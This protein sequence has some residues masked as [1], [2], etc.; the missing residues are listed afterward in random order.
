VGKRIRRIHEKGIFPM[1]HAKTFTMASLPPEG[2]EVRG[3][4]SGV[5]NGP[6]DDVIDA[7]FTETP[8]Q[9]SP[10]A[11]LPD[12]ADH[13]RDIDDLFQ[14]LRDKIRRRLLLLVC[15][16]PG[17]RAYPT[18]LCGLTGMK[19]EDV[20]RHLNNLRLRGFLRD[21]KDGQKLWYFAN[22]KTVRYETHGDRYA[23][24]LIGKS[25]HDVTLRGPLGAPSEN[26][27]AAP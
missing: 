21:E 16:A 20:S 25:G 8:P 24:T 10:H 18:M 26:R 23:L 2:Q 4:P 3:Q 1:Q 27:S 12:S 17:G 22:P 6:G 19:R 9:A 13:D 11:D 5:S 7:E 14:T 15:Q